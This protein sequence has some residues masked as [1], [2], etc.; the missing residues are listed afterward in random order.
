[1]INIDGNLFINENKYNSNNECTFIKHLIAI[2]K[3]YINYT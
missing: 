2:N 3:L 1:M